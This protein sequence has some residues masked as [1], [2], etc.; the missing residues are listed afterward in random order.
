MHVSKGGN[1][2]QLTIDIGYDQVFQL[3][4]QLSPKERERLAK[5]IVPAEQKTKCSREEWKQILASAPTLSPENAQEMEKSMKNF[6]KEFNDA[7]ESRRFR[8]F[9]PD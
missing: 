8:H 2:M 9:G 5:E 4:R 6:R 3:V 7:I 1:P